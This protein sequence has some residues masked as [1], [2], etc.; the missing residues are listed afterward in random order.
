MKSRKLVFALYRVV[1][2][3]DAA[4]PLETQENTVEV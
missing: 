4:A 3:R 2:Q 1:Y